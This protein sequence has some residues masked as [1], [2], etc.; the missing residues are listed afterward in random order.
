MP[1]REETWDEIASTRTDYPDLN[2]GLPGDIAVI[3]LTSPEQI[4]GYLI[5]QDVPEA[6][7]WY[8]NVGPETGWAYGMRLGIEQ[9]IATGLSM[10]W[11]P[12]KTW[13]FIRINYPPLH[14]EYAADLPKF[15]ASLRT[16]WA[17]AR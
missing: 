16:L 11:S 1:Y 12:T 13:S 9:A 14:T 6:L 10:K 7:E 8:T 3:G 5:K 2:N 15:Y 17:D 4:V